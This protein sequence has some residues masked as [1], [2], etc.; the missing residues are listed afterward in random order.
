MP[1][2]FG[3]KESLP[4]HPISGMVNKNGGKVRLTFK[5]DNDQVWIGKLYL[6]SYCAVLLIRKTLTE[7]LLLSDV[8]LCLRYQRKNRKGSPKL[9]QKCRERTYRRSQRISHCRLA[10]GTNGSIK[11]LDILG[12]CPICRCYQRCYTGQMATVLVTHANTSSLH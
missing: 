8:S 11:I 2:M 6:A 4:A 12:S 10:V 1:G 7:E 9:H 3:R 5:L